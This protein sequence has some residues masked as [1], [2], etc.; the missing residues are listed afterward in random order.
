LTA[1]LASLQKLSY[2][3]TAFLAS[4]QKKHDQFLTALLALPKTL[5]L[6]KEK[7]ETRFI[8]SE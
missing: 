1:L 5:T 7:K 6:G 3:L 8:R 4:P 2:F